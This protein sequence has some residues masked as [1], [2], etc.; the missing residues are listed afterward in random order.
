LVEENGEPMLEV[1]KSSDKG[2]LVGE[3]F[4]IPKPTIVT[5]SPAAE[6]LK[7]AIYEKLKS[8]ELEVT[9]EDGD[10]LVQWRIEKPFPYKGIEKVPG[11]RIAN[12]DAESII[13]LGKEIADRFMRR[14]AN[15]L[16]NLKP[17]SE[18]KKPPKRRD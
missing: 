13:Q 18:K 5:N 11:Y 12:V 17:K 9:I 4:K 14:S 3:R 8:G 6:S 2:C 7:Q 16:K 1:V 15:D 10:V